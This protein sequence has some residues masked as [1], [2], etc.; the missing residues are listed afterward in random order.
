[1]T[2]QHTQ[3]GYIA[4]LSIL[5]MGAVSLAIASALLIGGTD[6]QRETLALQQST[7]ARSLAT[8]CGEEAMQQIHDN[9]TFTGTS[10]LTLGAGNCTYTV[11][12][13]GGASRTILATGVVGNV[14]RSVQISA[15]VGAS[16]ISVVSWQ[17]TTANAG[18]GQ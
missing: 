13:T 17:D 2:Q 8:S 4:L 15:T 6:S 1:M 7:Q 12:N 9:T 5:I 14:T 10:S 3:S 18:S 16:A 11:T